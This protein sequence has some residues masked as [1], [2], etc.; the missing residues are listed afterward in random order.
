[1]IVG[2]SLNIIVLE[3]W[4]RTKRLKSKEN[5]GKSRSDCKILQCS[6][7]LN[8]KEYESSDLNLFGL[9]KAEI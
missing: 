4:D 6:R 9:R 2:G 8:S 1:M 3:N 7:A 5:H